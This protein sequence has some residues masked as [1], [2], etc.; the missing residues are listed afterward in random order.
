M[1]GAR[2]EVRRRDQGRHPGQLGGQTRGEL[3]V[4]DGRW[5]ARA[6]RTE[7]RFGTLMA[8]PSSTR[9]LTSEKNKETA[10]GEGATRR[11]S[12]RREGVVEARTLPIGSSCGFA[13]ALS[14]L[15]TR[16][17]AL[18]LRSA[19]L[20]GVGLSGPIGRVRAARQS[21]SSRSCRFRACADF[22]CWY[23]RTFGS[24]R[25]KAK[26]VV[27]GFEARAGRYFRVASRWCTTGVLSRRCSS[28]RSL[29]GRSPRTAC[30]RCA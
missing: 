19:R 20:L 15:D 2:R 10:S 11:V 5:S 16:A 17:R 23:R 25:A 7:A 22:K 14:A 30:T 12:R 1:V 18:V 24:Q 6:G 26:S 29:A 27:R 28:R 9:R 3:R 4:R 13:R 8:Q 21:D